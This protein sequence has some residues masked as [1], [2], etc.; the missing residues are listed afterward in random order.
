MQYLK[1][2]GGDRSAPTSD[3]IHV[4]Q[5]PLPSPINLERTLSRQHPLPTANGKQTLLWT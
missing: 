3:K 2:K 5:Q 1:E 4:A